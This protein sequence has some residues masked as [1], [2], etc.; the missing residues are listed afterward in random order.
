MKDMTG[1]EDL[2][3]FNDHTEAELVRLYLEFEEISF[4][5]TV[6]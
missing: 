3:S 4:E 5:T 1:Y 2:K 6:T